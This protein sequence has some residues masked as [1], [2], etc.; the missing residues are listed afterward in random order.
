MSNSLPNDVED[1]E[2]QI[3]RVCEKEAKKYGFPSFLQTVFPN[4]FI[5]RKDYSEQP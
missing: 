3:S 1:K 2:K 5:G 4:N